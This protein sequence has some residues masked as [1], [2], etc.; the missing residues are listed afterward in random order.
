MRIEQTDDSGVVILR[1]KDDRIDARSASDLKDRITDCVTGGSRWIVLDL[2]DVS[3]VDS[4]GLGA[5]ISGLKL[6]GEDG[7]LVISGIHGPVAA[8]LKLT[9]IDKIFRTFPTASDAVLALAPA[10]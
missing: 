6:I 7:D 5:L 9:R 2:S 1:V 4:S 8:L 3:F 10:H